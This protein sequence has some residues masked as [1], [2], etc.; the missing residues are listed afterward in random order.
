MRAFGFSLLFCLALPTG[1]A[2]AGDAPTTAIRSVAE[3][4][5]AAPRCGFIF[6]EEVGRKLLANEGYDPANPEHVEDLDYWTRSERT[7][8]GMRS[9]RRLQTE[10]DLLWQSF[11]PDGL[12]RK[13]L[14][15]K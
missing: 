4:M 1:V 11:G 7:V 12:V 6:A 8:W 15:R 9:E 5:A 14:L 2:L 3:T 13:G 10:C